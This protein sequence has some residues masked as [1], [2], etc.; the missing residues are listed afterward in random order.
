MG[1]IEKLVYKRGSRVVREILLLVSNFEI[2]PSTTVAKGLSIQHRGMG[3]VIHPATDIGENVTLYHQVTIGRQDGHVPAAQSPMKR[4]VI[5]DHA[6]LYPGSKVLGGAGVTTVG[7]GTI[8]AANAVLTQSTGE[9]E[10]WGGIPAK[11][12]GVRPRT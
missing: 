4:I 3:T 2:H 11:K 6:V 9:Y 1:L 7:R 10:V 8:L 12:I 5:G